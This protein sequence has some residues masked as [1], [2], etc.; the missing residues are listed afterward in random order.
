MNQFR[1]H[2]WRD[3][4]TI[5]A[6]WDANIDLTG[7]V[8]ALNLYDRNWPVWTY[9]QQLP[10]AKFVHNHLDRRGTAIESSVSSGCIVSGEVNRSLLFS[11]SRV[12]SYAG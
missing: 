6:Y 9:Q 4:G 2:Y 8:P 11:G 1:E 10:P 5:D 7:T 3:A 12:H